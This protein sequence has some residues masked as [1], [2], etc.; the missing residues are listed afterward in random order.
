MGI[1]MIWGW[2]MSFKMAC[3]FHG[4]FAISYRE[5][6]RLVDPRELGRRW[7]PWKLPMP[8]IRNWFY[9][10]FW[11]SDLA[12]WMK[13]WPESFFKKGQL[14]THTHNLTVL[15]GFVGD[16]TC[17]LNITIVP[18]R[19][20]VFQKKYSVYSTF[21]MFTSHVSIGTWFWCVTCF[22]PP[23]CLKGVWVICKLLV[24]LNQYGC[25]KSNWSRC[26]QWTFF[27]IGF[28]CWTRFCWRHSVINSGDLLN[29]SIQ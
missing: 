20:V 7:R 22:Y 10:R 24:I 19:P 23:V 26:E 12:E 21:I 8:P 3:F 13:R 27:R 5:A 16:T 2:H 17:K 18:L 14:Y 4:F 15:M 1:W 28:H 29:H 6:D 9:R 11:I 25:P